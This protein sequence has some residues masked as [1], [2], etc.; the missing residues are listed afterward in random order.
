MIPG[1]F[2]KLDHRVRSSIVSWIWR[3][4]YVFF[5]ESVEYGFYSGF[6]DIK[7]IPSSHGPL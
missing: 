1:M 4:Q 3:T 5:D 6:E 7:D 2:E